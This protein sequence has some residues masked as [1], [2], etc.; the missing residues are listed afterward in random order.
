M[1]KTF[2]AGQ[3]VRLDVSLTP[4]VVVERANLSG[5]ITNAVTKQAV[6]YALV[7]VVDTVRYNRTDSAG[8]Y[9]IG[10]IEPGVQTIRITHGS[11]KPKEEVLTFGIGEAKRFTTTLV[12]ISADIGIISGYVT[13]SSSGKPI[14]KA[15]VQALYEAAAFTNNDGYYEID[16][17]SPQTY[18]VVCYAESYD[19]GMLRSQRVY[20]GQTTEANISLRSQPGVAEPMRLPRRMVCVGAHPPASGFELIDDYDG[21]HYY[22]DNIYEWLKDPSIEY[23][24]LQGIHGTGSELWLRVRETSPLYEKTIRCMRLTYLRIQECLASRQSFKLV[25]LGGCGTLPPG[26]SRLALAFRANAL[27]QAKAWA[28]A[29][30]SE[31]FRNLDK[32]LSAYQAYVNAGG[33]VTRSEVGLLVYRGDNRPGFKLVG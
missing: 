16:G 3:E 23:A 6:A 29:K 4:K 8:N 13:D 7:K 18:Q 27:G 25:Y 9:Y 22:A 12:P 5:R 28:G 26:G 2:V 33:N 30:G 1:V 14:A 24:Y 32:G 11:Y 21:T 15:L 10:L 20:A 17:L 31:F 19:I